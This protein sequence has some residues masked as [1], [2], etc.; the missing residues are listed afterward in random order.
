MA[1]ASATGWGRENLR[2]GRWAKISPPKK[3]HS[4]AEICNSIGFRSSTVPVTTASIHAEELDDEIHESHRVDEIA[5]T[6]GTISRSNQIQ[7]Q[8]YSSFAGF[9]AEVEKRN[10]TPERPLLPLWLVYRNLSLNFKVFASQTGL[11]QSYSLSHLGLPPFF[12][13]VFA[14]AWPK[15]QSLSRS[16]NDYILDHL[17]LAIVGAKS[18]NSDPNALRLPRLFLAFG[19]ATAPKLRALTKPESQDQVQPGSGHSNRANF[20]PANVQLSTNVEEEPN[21]A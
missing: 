7:H 13:L 9:P 16:T 19:V 8:Q 21:F 10:R 6:T 17:T 5:R 14:V 12:A 11:A 1:V 3:S 15:R 4:I 2:W 18:S 20:Q